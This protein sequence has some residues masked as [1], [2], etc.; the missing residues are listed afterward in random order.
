MRKL[1]LILLTAMVPMAMMAQFRL[2]GNYYSVPSPQGVDNVIIFQDLSAADAYIEYTGTGTPK[3]TTLANAVKQ[4]GVGAERL[5]PD[6]GEGYLLYEGDNLLASFFVFDYKN[7]LPN[8]A[9]A[10][11]TA[12]MQCDK[13]FLTLS[14]VVPEMR[15]TTTAGG[16]RVVDRQATV[17]YTTLNWGGEGWQDSLAQ[18]DVVLQYGVAT[19]QLAIDA[20]FTNT[21]FVLHLDPFVQNWNALSD[22]VVSDE[23]KAIAVCSHPVSVTTSRDYNGK[24]MENEP[25]RPIEES[26]LTGSAPLE[27]NFLSNGNKPVAQYFKWQIFKGSDLLVERF[28]EDQ[29]YTFTENGAY[30]VKCWVYNDQCTTDSTV[31]DISVSE[32]LL[33]VPNVFTPNGDGTN[34]EFRVVYRSLAEFHCWIYN[35]WGHLVFQWDDPAKGWDGTINGKPAAEGAYYYIIRARGTN[36]PKDAK[37]HKAT[38]RNPADVGVYQLSGHINLIRGKQN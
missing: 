20:P 18:A 1:F 14:G 5:Y 23:Y 2:S 29:R 22:S 21:S 35:R 34:D 19:Q 36:A 26:A 13:S 16:T 32:S 28:D 17:A 25:M 33:K 10:T 38:K 3:W 4:Q 15:Y 30:Q 6:D 27:I 9:A 8:F 11:L 24:G 37:Y 7:Y 31:F 12:D